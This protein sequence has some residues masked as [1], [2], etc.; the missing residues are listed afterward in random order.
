MKTKTKFFSGNF[1]GIKSFEGKVLKVLLFY[2]SGI[3]NYPKTPLKKIHRISKDG[4]RGKQ[5]KTLE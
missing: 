4:K 1:D 3:A 5:I 2:T